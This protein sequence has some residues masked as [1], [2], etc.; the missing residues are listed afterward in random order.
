MIC[1]HGGDPTLVIFPMPPPDARRTQWEHHSGVVDQENH[2]MTVGVDTVLPLNN[3]QDA[4]IEGICLAWVMAFM[5]SYKIILA[6][7]MFQ[8]NRSIKV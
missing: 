1:W 7:R 5:T 2:V 6:R 3:V 8:N 4:L